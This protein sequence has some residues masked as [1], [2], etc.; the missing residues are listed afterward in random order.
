MSIIINNKLKNKDYGIRNW[1]RLHCLRYMYWWMSGRGYLWG[2]ALF[3]W[4]RRV[5]RVWHLRWCLS[6]WGNFTSWVNKAV[7]QKVTSG[8]HTGAA[9]VVFMIIKSQV[10]YKISI[11]LI[12]IVYTLNW[13]GQMYPKQTWQPTSHSA[14]YVARSYIVFPIYWIIPFYAFPIWRTC[15]HIRE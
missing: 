15:V 4:P 3:N 1:W 2:R 9:F 8:T 6:F 14:F 11:I 7:Q 10:F 12:Q 5:H 13:R